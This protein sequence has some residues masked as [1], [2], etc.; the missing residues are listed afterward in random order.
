MPVCLPGFP[1]EPG[2]EIVATVH[3]KF[4]QR[5]M[6]ATI[7]RFLDGDAPFHWVGVY[8]VVPGSDGNRY[9]EICHFGFSDE[10]KARQLLGQ[11]AQCEDWMC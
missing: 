1:N 5:T 8:L 11:I 10:T 9:H 2:S 7:E 6:L 3:L 4:Q